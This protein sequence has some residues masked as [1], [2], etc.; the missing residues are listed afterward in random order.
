[1]TDK[2]RIRLLHEH[3]NKAFSQGFYT[4]AMRYAKKALA[5]EKKLKER[6]G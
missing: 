4:T 6:Q 3:A 1:M 5:L 2:D